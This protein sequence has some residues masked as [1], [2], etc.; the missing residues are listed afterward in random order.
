MYVQ[1]MEQLHVHVR[2]CLSAAQPQA[3]ECYTG[4]HNTGPT[5]SMATA[6]YSD[7]S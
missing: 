6:A 3:T 1:N 2:D 4:M 7:G 5:S